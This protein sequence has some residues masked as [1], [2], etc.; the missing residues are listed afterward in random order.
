M[1]SKG[2][3]TMV[4]VGPV[5]IL[6]QRIRGRKWNKG[7][8]W[9]MVMVLLWGWSCVYYLRQHKGEDVCSRGSGD[10]VQGGSN[11][12]SCWSF[13]YSLRKHWGKDVCSRGSGDDV[14]GG[15]NNGSCNVLCVFSN[16]GAIVCHAASNQ[17][18]T[19]KSTPVVAWIRGRK[20]NKGR[21]WLMA[22]V[23]LWGWSC[24]YYLRQHKR[25]DVFEGVWR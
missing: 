13:A 3:R 15:S 22:M 24:V 17:D 5:C 25:K 7:R 20:W 16:R 21:W 14:Q 1:M 12:G 11:N 10:D 19:R 18:K 2:A 8:W 23:L 6:Q 9:L 4:P